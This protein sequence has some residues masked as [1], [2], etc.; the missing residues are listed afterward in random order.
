MN[1]KS[2]AMGNRIS[3]V[4]ETIQNNLNQKSEY[5]DVYDIALATGLVK[6]IN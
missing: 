2:P 6:K 5:Q 4:L 3:D 1:K